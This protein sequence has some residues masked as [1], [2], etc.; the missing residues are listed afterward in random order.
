VIVLRHLKGRITVNDRRLHTSVESS[1]SQ[2]GRETDTNPNAPRKTVRCAER[3]VEVAS[4]PV[5]LTGKAAIGENV[6]VIVLGNTTS[7]LLSATRRASEAKRRMKE[8]LVRM[9]SAREKATTDSELEALGYLPM[10]LVRIPVDTV[11]VEGVH[12]RIVIT[13]QDMAI[14]M[15]VP[16][17]HKVL[18]ED[19]VSKSVS[20]VTVRGD[21]GQEGVVDGYYRRV[22]VV[23][24]ECTGKCRCL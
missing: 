2:H 20:S 5:S 11:Y 3:R 7:E 18:R 8:E 14:R 6:R 9:M 17:G 10:T 19:G 15:T 16:G 24:C 13:A 12:V 21:H 1:W 4:P 22:S 23:C